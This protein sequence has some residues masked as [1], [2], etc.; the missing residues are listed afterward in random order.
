MR[1]ISRFTRTA[2]SFIFILFVYMSAF[3]PT[4]L[5]A[6]AQGGPQRVLILHSYHQGLSWT[7]DVQAAFSAILAQSGLS[8]EVDVKYLDALR[9]G[10]PKAFRRNM[11]LLHRQMVDQ[12]VGKQFDMVLVS[13]NSA[14]D[15]LLE[16]RESLTG[17]APVVFCGIN[18]FSPEMLRGQSNITGVA[19]TPSLDSTIELALKLRP[20]ASKLLILAEET[21]SGKANQALLHA[22]SS[23]FSSLV[24]IEVW[25]ETDIYKLE[26][27]LAGL[28]PE[29]V[30]LPMV[31]PLDEHG[32][33]SAQVASQRLS[34]A[35]TVPLF[36]A[37]DFWMGHG[38]VAGVVVSA[39]NHGETAG[40]MAIRILKGERA[41]SIPMVRQENNVS[42]A[43]HLAMTRFGMSESLLP[44]S[45]VILNA[46]V[47]FYTV[48][49]DIFW[50]GSVIGLCLFFL[51]VFLALNVSRRKRAEQSM[52]LIASRLIVAQQI[53]QIG[54]WEWIVEED[55]VTWS[56]QMFTLLGLDPA[57]QIPTYE[58]N[59]ALYHDEDAQQ[60]KAAVS[61]AISDGTPYVLELKRTKPDGSEI[62]VQARGLTEKDATGK[63][64]RLYGSV[65]DI[66]ERKRAEASLNS[67]KWLVD[68]GIR[69]V[70]AFKTSYY[71]DLV[72]LNTSR[73]IL[74]AVGSD[75]LAE[76]V[77]DYMAIL[78]T[79]S[80]VYERDGGYALGIFAS[81]WC[82]TMDQAS[83]RLCGCSS[84]AEALASGKWLC[85]ESCWTDA[86][87]TAIETRLPVDI[88]CK[89]GIR[90]YAVPIRSGDEIVGA[91][92]FGYGTPPRDRKVISELAAI[93]QTDP[94]ELWKLSMEYEHRPDFIIDTAKQRLNTTARL[95]GEMVTRSMVEQHLQKAMQNAEAA[96]RAKSE[97][98]ANMSH[99]IR[100]PLNG[101]LGMLQLLKASTLDQEQ[102]EFCALASQSTNRL[103]SLLSDI[104]DLSRVEACK[105]LI[106]S[107]RFNVRSALTQ[108]I[109]L[110]EP[111]A[112]QTGVALT[113]HLDTDLPTWA[114]GDSIRLQQVLT[115][116]I[117]NAFKFTKRG[118][119]HVEAYA[120]PSRSND[121]LRV[122]F[123]IEDT[124]CGIA[125]EELENLFQPFTQV[126]QGY[127]RNHQ[128]A[129]L[130]LII[131]KQLVALMG[132]N[133][134]ME[135]EEGVGTTFA[136]CMT[137]GKEA[138]SHDDETALESRTA[139]LASLQI[140]LAED[141][142][143]TLFSIRRLLEKSGHSVTV[144]RNGQEA[145]EMHEVNDF[146]LILMDV[147][148]PIMDG[149]V[150][151]QRI[152]DL[153][154]SH[155]RD[156]PIIALTAYAMAGD[157]E[158][159]L[160]AGMN[161]YVAKPLNME[162]LKQMMAETLAEQRR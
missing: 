133:M 44:E 155:K 56:D 100:T 148:M 24:E 20:K 111:I 8:I 72:P 75:I 27:S 107:E 151:C 62:C 84:N 161:G 21:P 41:E 85:H 162:S 144:A 55:K 60:L 69:P 147:S 53:A 33:L 67:I 71:G 23:H 30:V 13:D 141:D 15:F 3:L 154:N 66:T 99:E 10:D 134:A 116:L 43:D 110:F 140:L 88:A 123:A 49:K 117:G 11:E 18:N 145:L 150:A 46:P 152:R 31:R 90:L 35:S 70:L 12:F 81:N 94:D 83:R 101:I 98:L 89:G 130:G 115:N 59:L 92:N 64:I 136:F 146:D 149:I 25:K 160:A 157:K 143:T 129:G 48:N 118:H 36:A 156:I 120:L 52:N 19:E 124:G 96:N 153:R 159:F 122:F 16:H 80:A 4:L 17:N 29:W 138:Q 79:S 73:V 97:F 47:S 32:M 114:V 42:M 142:E 28:G 82:Q 127:T 2:F 104:L 78:G 112:V 95:I 51:S 7:D 108:T 93:Y 135:S 6:Q 119:V 26:A 45:T 131:S 86:S 9:M 1:P 158:K 139:P 137:F 128:G 40:A 76:V 61:Q 106:R 34:R 54:D 68:K 22:Q 87:R 14:L 121:T 50:A 37:W 126:S 57:K 103:T 105:L 38:P 109:D 132:G 77:L 125:D 65:Q 74:N 102:A 91:I 113:R 63:V 39:N 58:E 5:T